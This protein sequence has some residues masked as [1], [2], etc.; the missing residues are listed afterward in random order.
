MQKINL[1]SYKE[2]AAI[3]SANCMSG[4]CEDIVTFFVDYAR[5]SRDFMSSELKSSILT[6]WNTLL[7]TANTLVKSLD[8]ELEAMEDRF[9]TIRNDFGTI[10]Q[11]LCENIEQCVDP[12]VTDFFRKGKHGA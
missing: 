7:S 1:A 3:A 6:P 11:N 9:V 8:L 10:Q 12:A 2:N 4:K 5:R